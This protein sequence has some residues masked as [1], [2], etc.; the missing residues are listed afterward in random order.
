L[1][2]RKREKTLGDGTK[3]VSTRTFVIKSMQPRLMERIKHS[4]EDFSWKAGE[5]CYMGPIP[6]NERSQRMVLYWLCYYN[7]AF[8]KADFEKLKQRQVLAIRNAPLLQKWKNDLMNMHNDTM[9][10]M[11]SFS[12][13]ILDNVVNRIGRHFISGLAL[14]VSIVG[15]FFGLAAIGKILAPTPMS[16]NQPNRKGVAMPM[17]YLHEST[18][19]LM[20]AQKA[21]YEITLVGNKSKTGQAVGVQGSIFLINQH[22][23][24]DYDKTMEVFIY[25]HQQYLEDKS[26]GVKRY[27]VTKADISLIPDSDCALINITGFRAVRTVLGHFITERDCEDRMMNFRTGMYQT[28]SL[29]ATKP[30]DILNE[31]SGGE[32]K[33]FATG[34]GRGQPLSCDLQERSLMFHTPNKVRNGDSGGLAIHDNTKISGKFCGI[35]VAAL[36]DTNTAYIGIVTQEMLVKG[37]K[38]FPSHARIS[39]HPKGDLI[40]TCNSQLLPVFDYKHEVYD[41]PIHN[42]GVSKSLGFVKSPIHGVLPVESIPAIQDYRDSRQPEGA[43]HHLY[44]SLNKTN[45]EVEPYFSKDDKDFMRNFAKANIK[46]HV[47]GLSQLRLYNYKQSICGIRAKGSASI[48]TKTSP[49]LPYKLEKGVQ[50]KSPFIKY[51]ETY[52]NWDI[53][54]RVYDDCDMY[55]DK[56]ESEQIPF[57]YKVEFRKKELVAHEKITNPKT[58]TVATGNFIHQVLYGTYTKDLFTMIKNVWEDGGSSPFALGV[59]QERHWN[60]VAKHLKY[61][62]CVYDFDIK[63]WEKKICLSLLLLNCDVFYS[64][65]KEAYESR[66]ETF[67][68]KK[69]VVEG[70]AV[71]FT[72]TEVIFE[73]VM[74]RKRSGLLS[75]HPGTFMENSNI[76][77]MLI[78]LIAYRIL[79]RKQPAWAN[80][81]FIMEHMRVILAADDVQIAL[82]P[83]LRSII[84]TEEILDGYK[85]LTFEV[86]AADKSN[87]IRRKRLTE[88]QFLKHTYRENENGEF[89][90]VPN[91]SIIYQ[92]FNWLRDDT[93]LTLD[94]QFSIDLENGFR[95][96]YWRGEKEYE[97]IRR[98]V[99]KA[100]LKENR[101]WTYTHEQLG[102]I[103]GYQ[104]AETRRLANSPNATQEE[105]L[106]YEV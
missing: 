20:L 67:P 68:L 101:E 102:A 59:D 57:N 53:Q 72:D 74:Y 35:L 65:Y 95:F 32:R 27:Q 23:I 8:T 89:E 44:V 40:P 2:E 30:F 87:D 52:K 63:A 28:I 3:E 24:P 90:A 85:E 18:Q 70:L 104:M 49:G 75:G 80:S 14:A 81:A 94:E 10:A 98:T 21:T 54:Q 37:M 77:L 105:S 103:I 1:E 11:G 58:R 86:T 5:A 93:K 78:G 42:Q 34:F 99:N 69:S 61:H 4:P 17:A 92:L 51:N 16:Y 56:Y 62:D 97:E 39:K 31:N 46:K 36:D 79:K 22:T 26:T 60:Q 6:E 55:M 96:A 7:K 73:D 29:R 47:P 106:D 9:R 91:T 100:L 82:S 45:G 66:G 84:S 19:D 33:W 43:R 38:Q 88:S 50:G 83:L 13:W 25:D 12:K 76:H 15:M 64:L 41:S 71:D 48:N